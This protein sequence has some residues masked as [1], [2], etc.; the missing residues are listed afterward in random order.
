M[1][2]DKVDG[3]YL[4]SKLTAQLLALREEMLQQ[5]YARERNNM[6]P[7]QSL[8]LRSQISYITGVVEPGTHEMWPDYSPA[9]KQYLEDQAL[10][11]A[12]DANHIAMA[13]L[14]P[15]AA[16]ALVA[17]KAE[18]SPAVVSNLI[19]MGFN[20]TAVMWTGRNGVRHVFAGEGVPLEPIVN[21]KNHIRLVSSQPSGT[22]S[23]PSFVAKEPPPQVDKVVPDVAD[24]KPDGPAMNN[25]DFD[26][27]AT[28]TRLQ[29]FS[30]WR[31]AARKQYDA[32][33]RSGEEVEPILDWLR[34][35]KLE[36][37]GVAL[38]AYGDG[39][40]Q[41]LADL[42]GSVEGAGGSIDELLEH[43][44]LFPEGRAE[45]R[46]HAQDFEKRLVEDIFGANG[47]LDPT[48]LRLV[49]AKLNAGQYMTA[50][51]YASLEYLRDQ[52]HQT[53]VHQAVDTYLGLYKRINL[54]GE[55]GPD[56]IEDA[57]A[58][59]E[60][61]SP[62]AIKKTEHEHQFVTKPDHGAEL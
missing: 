15:F 20:A 17:D 14:G 57:R 59:A 30:N 47:E 44:R 37:L 42:K 61:A 54:A 3:I 5:F 49:V 8:A 52:A 13:A 31:T 21:V 46:I 60:V 18:A 41:M 53:F 48:K 25:G 27:P 32:A 29:D 10:K 6:L 19:E 9:E 26:K 28:V 40:G 7:E 4:S 58:E 11:H 45:A 55:P 12:R 50:R 1:T 36:K 24:V 16:A 23:R 56:V 22:P 34:A 2:G 43:Y 62:Y 51:D 35:P 38:H 33:I 39:R